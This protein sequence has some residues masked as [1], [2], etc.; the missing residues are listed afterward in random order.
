MTR[1]RALGLPRA[2]AIQSRR[3]FPFQ[4]WN[5]FRRYPVPSNHP[6]PRIEPCP[7]PG[8]R[9]RAW[10]EPPSLLW[11]P[12]LDGRP[13]LSSSK[14]AQGGVKPWLGS[15][16]LNRLLP[17]PELRRFGMLLPGDE[18]YGIMR[19][20]RP[21]HTAAEAPHGIDVNLLQR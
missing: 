21:A 15:V 13:V 8:R 1:R 7:E 19:A 14:E 2:T 10:R 17:Q 16:A 12:S 20:D 3:D 6:E 11:F 18:G 4:R 9:R 5:S